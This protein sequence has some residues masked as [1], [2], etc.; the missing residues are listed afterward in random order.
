MRYVRILKMLW[1][2]WILKV[3]CNLGGRLSGPLSVGGA[4]CSSTTCKRNS[5]PNQKCLCDL[6]FVILH[7]NHLQHN[8]ITGC[9]YSYFD[10][11]EHFL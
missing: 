11:G 9:R 2:G 1:V 5:Q 10:I 3:T 8:Q 7:H 4:R 6:P